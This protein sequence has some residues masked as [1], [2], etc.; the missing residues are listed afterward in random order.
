MSTDT[1]NRIAHAVKS[2]LSQ[3]EATD[4]MGTLTKAVAQA[5]NA[6][7]AMYAVQ[8]AA[9]AEVCTG[10]W[11]IVKMLIE[12]RGFEPVEALRMVIDQTIKDIIGQGAD[13]NWSGRGN[14]LM[15][16]RFDALRR[17]VQEA[18]YLLPQEA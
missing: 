4:P 7:D 13:D 14:D 10:R 8:H 17:W 12:D 9:E 18:G 15:R 1:T 3:P 5:R 16:V 6:K 11:Q 2:A